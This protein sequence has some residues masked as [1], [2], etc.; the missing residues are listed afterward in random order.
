MRFVD[1]GVRVT[2]TSGGR[3]ILLLPI[4]YSHALSARASRGSAKLVRANLAQ[5][6]LVFERE[7]DVLL[8]LRF[9]F[10]QT[11]GRAQDMTDTVTLGIREDGSR[12]VSPELYESLHPFAKLRLGRPEGPR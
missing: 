12:R 10:G 3:S 8:T 11:Q 2:A 1:G 7:V 4:Q 9:G 5:T 6:G